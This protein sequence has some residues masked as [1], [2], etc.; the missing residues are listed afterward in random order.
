MSNAFV[1]IKMCYVYNQRYDISC[2]TLC[3]KKIVHL[4]GIVY[5]IDFLLRDT[6]TEVAAACWRRIIMWD[7][8]YL[9]I[10]LSCFT[11]LF[12]ISNIHQC[13]DMKHIKPLKT[14]GILVTGGA[15]TV[16]RHIQMCVMYRPVWENINIFWI[17]SIEYKQSVILVHKYS[18]YVEKFE[19]QHPGVW[20]GKAQSV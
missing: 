18:F 19:L 14:F 16:R 8:I 17:T 10:Y 3:M 13:T 12:W 9:N 4:V 7:W 20:A 15:I 1:A 6:L 2:A 11:I 5:K